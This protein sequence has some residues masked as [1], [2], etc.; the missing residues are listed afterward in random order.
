MQ[1]GKLVGRTDTDYFYFKCPDCEHLFRVLDYVFTVDHVPEYTVNLIP[2]PRR[3]FTIALHLY[4]QNCG[5]V[6]FVK[7]SNLVWQT[8]MFSNLRTRGT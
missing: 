8:G 2:N 4:C 5:V 6:D 3:E 1:G 7:V